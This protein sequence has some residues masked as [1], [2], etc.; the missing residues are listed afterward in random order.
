MGFVPYL[1]PCKLHVVKHLRM[2]TYFR[3]KFRIVIFKMS[4]LFGKKRNH[5]NTNQYFTKTK[6]KVYNQ[7]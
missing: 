5:G 2:V 1:I 7:V 3:E 4:I 6:Q